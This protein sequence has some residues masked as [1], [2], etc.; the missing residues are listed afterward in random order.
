MSL[1]W[2]GQTYSFEEIDARAQRVAAILHQRGL[3]PGDRLCVQL[4]NS[5]EM[6][7]VYLACGKLGVILRSHQ[8][9]VSR[10][11]SVAHSG[12]RGTEVVRYAA[13]TS[14]IGRGRLGG[15]EPSSRRL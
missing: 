10:P 13:R 11:R 15:S 3:R 6:L 4:P 12:R 14:G 2:N 5:I 8:C 7:D 9:S 1:E